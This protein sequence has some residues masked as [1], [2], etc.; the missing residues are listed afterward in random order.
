MQG[1][2]NGCITVLLVFLRKFFSIVLVSLALSLIKQL[3][4]VGN[5]SHLPWFCAWQ[6]PPQYAAISEQHQPAELIPRFST[7]EYTITRSQTMPPIFL[8]VVDTCMDDEELAALKESLQCSLSILPPNALIGLITY[9]KM[10]QVKLLDKMHIPWTI[11]NHTITTSDFD[12]ILKPF[13]F[14]LQCCRCTNWAGRASPSHTCSAATR[15]SR[16]SRC[17]TCWAWTGP[18]RHRSSRRSSRCR[19]PATTGRRPGRSSTRRRPA[20]SCGPSALAT[21]TWTTCSASCS[22]IPGPSSRASGRCAPPAPPSP[23][24]SDS[25]RYRRRYAFFLSETDA[26]VAI[27]NGRAFILRKK[28]E[29]ISV[30]KRL[31]G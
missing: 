28:N 29:L 23:S 27:A 18:C 7:I 31:V 21:W 6:F 4:L 30:S 17:R 3:T 14:V 24:P 10:V 1:T 16:P 26:P 12:F 11:Q 20:A 2:V 19:W 13:S 8:L 5:V 25:S 9:G 22:A 15:T